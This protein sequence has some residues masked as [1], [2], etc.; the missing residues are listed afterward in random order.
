LLI[1]KSLTEFLDA[2]IFQGSQRPYCP[3]AKAIKM[4]KH[5]T[6]E[7]WIDF[8]NQV[9]AKTQRA[10]MQEHLDSGCKRCAKTVALW[11]KTRAIAA[12]EANFQPPA[13]AVRIAKAAFTGANLLPHRESPAGLL[14][15]LFDSFSQPALAG[16]RSAPTAARQLLY[17]ADPYQVHLQIEA[18]PDRGKLVITGQLMDLNNVESQSPDIQVMLSNLRGSVTY[19][20]T[21]SFGEFRGEVENSGDLELTFPRS[22]DRSIV[23]S[24]R[25]ALS[26]L[27]GAKS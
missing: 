5:F 20:T 19:T 2:Y 10:A 15:L 25:H 3:E 16:A 12:S 4:T 14:E 17:R 13:D 1:L 6:E 7:E 11:Q 22:D 26:R 18:K 9:A 27:P 23:I 8:V 24:L 21:N